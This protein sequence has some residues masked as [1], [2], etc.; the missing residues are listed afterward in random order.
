V[1]FVGACICMQARKQALLAV[2]GRMASTHPVMATDTRMQHKPPHTPFMPMM[3][4]CGGGALR[5]MPTARAFKMHCHARP[6]SQAAGGGVSRLGSHHRSHRCISTPSKT[7]THHPHAPLAV[8]PC[9]HG[10]AEATAVALLATASSRPHNPRQKIRNAGHS[11]ACNCCN[12]AAIR[13]SLC[14]RSHSMHPLT[15]PSHNDKLTQPV[16]G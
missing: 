16:A 1:A 8:A 13:S 9:Q 12:A 10:M 7:C 6:F 2:C 11:P 15:Q 5:V 3:C 4:V 14:L